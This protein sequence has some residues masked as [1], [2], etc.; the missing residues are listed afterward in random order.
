MRKRKRL[1]YKERGAKVSWRCS[2]NSRCA[3]RGAGSGVGVP[4]SSDPPALPLPHTD[5]PER[6]TLQPGPTREKPQTQLP[7]RRGNVRNGGDTPAWPGSAAAAPRS[8]RFLGPSPGCE[9]EPLR[10]SAACRAS[11]ASLP[12]PAQQRGHSG[13]GQP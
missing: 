12:S 5:P 3:A 10:Q 1:N 2:A 13:S 6:R 7:R 4:S 11:A 9:R 8:G